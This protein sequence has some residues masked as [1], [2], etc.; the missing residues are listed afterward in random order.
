MVY[1]KNY[2]EKNKPN[3]VVALNAEEPKIFLISLTSVTPGIV[4][5]WEDLRVDN[6]KAEDRGLPSFSAIASL[7]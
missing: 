3:L 7:S 5:D 6:K 1:K 2:F 4:V